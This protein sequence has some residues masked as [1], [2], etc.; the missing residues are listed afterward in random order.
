M[1]LRNFILAAAMLGAVSSPL[2][3]GETEEKAGK[4]KLY[5][6]IRNYLA[7]DSRESVSGTEDLFYYMPLD[8]DYSS[9]GTDLNAVSSF[10]AAA[11]TSRLGVDV[12]GYEF[13]NWK[14][15]AKIEADFY[16]GV[17]G[18]TGTAQF[19]M[20]QAYVTFGQ[21]KWV[22]KM[23]QAWHPMAADQPDVLA[24]N[25]GAPFNAFSRTPL[26][27]Y[28][29][30]FA[31]NFSLTVG[32]IWQMQ[33]TSTGPDGASAD[34]IKYGK[35][36]EFYFGVNFQNKN[37]LARV[38]VDVL[39][40][41]PRHIDDDGNKLSDR[42]TTVSPYVYFQYAKG[43]FALKA[44]SILAQGGE[45]LSLNGGYGVS[46]I[47]DDGSWEY[48]PT[49]NSSSWISLKY[50]RRFYGVLFAGYAKN[51]G[52]LSGDLLSS[53]Y[54]YFSKNSYSNMNQM[55]R[56][57][58]TLFYKIGKL[59]FGLEYDVTGVQYGE[60]GEDQSYGLA[61]ENLH[62]VTNHRVQGM[63]KFDF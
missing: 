12:V 60:W 43:D 42:I 50:G 56:V 58:P 18:V 47:N 27:T 10:R 23:G 14:M 24:L 16:A 17:T 39:S 37:F 48:S 21:N 53:N 59:T 29:W 1:K 40:I 5:G 7:F 61:T 62:W 30:K 52:V 35:T 38:G 2:F 44:K 51:L 36:P 57:T 55:W 54:L 6:F 13:G 19:R 4:I 3:A 41:K 33:Y 25:A 11:L 22:F 8:V 49:T 63:V 9:D 46:K 15:G 31:G 34:Y 20:R 32:A 45:H 28:D 26:L